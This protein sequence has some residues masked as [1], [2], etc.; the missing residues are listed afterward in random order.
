MVAQSL[1]LL[2]GVL[3]E[4]PQVV[5][6]VGV[7][8]EPEVVPYH[9]AVAVAGIVELFV[10][11]RADPVADHVEMHVPVECDAGVVLLAA[12]AE[13]PF[14]HAPVAAL[15][16]DRFAVDLQAED[17]VVPL[18]AVFADAERYCPCV[19]LPPVGFE[20]QAAGVQ[21][22][23]A[24]AVGPPEL[25]MLYGQ[26][27]NLALR[28]PDRPPLARFETDGV[29]E[30]DASGADLAPQHA[31]A[32]LVSVVLH[33]GKEFDLRMFAVGNLRAHPRFDEAYVA[34][35]RQV[36]IVGDA[37]QQPRGIGHPVPP[38]AGDIGR[39]AEIGHGVSHPFD[40]DFEA[41]LPAGCHEPGDVVVPR[42]HEAV[43]VPQLM[44]V[45]ADGTLAV[46][47]FEAEPQGAAFADRGRWE[48]PR[49]AEIAVVAALVR[50]VGVVAEIGVC[51][52]AGRNVRRE[53]AA[54][55][56]GR[57][58]GQGVAFRRPYLPTD[59]SAAAVERD[60]FLCADAG[61]E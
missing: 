52:H 12:A 54:G 13:Q 32:G 2:H 20:H 48:E 36:D 14:A 61:G 10:G 58:G 23:V 34:R 22:G 56:D 29:R 7:R 59:M 40:L 43:E 55:H 4:G 41:V 1:D 5:R 51:F 3:L 11:R 15:D 27:G 44:A 57:D 47:P 33:V 30:G 38:G 42:L 17:A 50:A 19:R 9:D 25:R 21:R 35:E 16:I 49:V 31:L 6:Q 37:A 28:E 46:H 8:V 26:A 39:A 18:V 60:T 24:H 45:E 53:D